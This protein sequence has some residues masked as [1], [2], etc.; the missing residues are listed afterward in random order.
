MRFVM[1][2]WQ[3][4]LVLM[5]LGVLL[6]G[7]VTGLVLLIVGRAKGR[8]GLWMAGLICLIVSL[9]IIGVAL[10][11]AITLATVRSVG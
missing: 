2:G 11:L 9:L 10:A 6:A 8:R 4:V 5:V 1:I 7:F 3:E